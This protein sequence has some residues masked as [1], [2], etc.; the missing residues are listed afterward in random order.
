MKEE[1]E[2]KQMTLVN[3]IGLIL[4][5]TVSTELDDL[6]LN[7]GNMLAQGCGLVPNWRA[8]LLVLRTDAS[9]YSCLIQH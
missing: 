1:W 9:E 5:S 4:L 6:I 3:G 8:S 2:K 7:K